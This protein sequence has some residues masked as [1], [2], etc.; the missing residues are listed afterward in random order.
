MIVSAT[1]YDGAVEVVRACPA[2]QAPGAILEIR[3]LAGA[4]G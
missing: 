4:A 3:E 2:V 1:D